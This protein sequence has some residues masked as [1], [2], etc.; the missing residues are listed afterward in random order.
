MNKQSCKDIINHQ[1]HVQLFFSDSDTYL[2]D[3]NR[4]HTKKKYLTFDEGNFVLL[5][6]KWF[7]A[8]LALNVKLIFA[9]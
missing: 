8:A 9:I 5:Q 3:Q 6:N 1:P 4:S 7:D 2:P